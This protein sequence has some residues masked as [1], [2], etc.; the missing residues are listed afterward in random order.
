[1]KTA[2]EYLTNQGIAIPDD[3]D[4]DGR[5]LVRVVKAEADT[6]LALMSRDAE[7]RRLRALLREVENAGPQGSCPFCLATAGDW[8]PPGGYPPT[9]H[10][11]D[12]RWLAEMGEGKR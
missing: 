5:K 2:R 11:P 8:P 9:P 12:C 7:I 1:M 10:A 4:D 6:V 3:T